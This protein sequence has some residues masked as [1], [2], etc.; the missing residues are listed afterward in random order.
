MSQSIMPCPVCDASSPS[1][2][3]E[4]RPGDIPLLARATH[5]GW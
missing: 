5:A 3:A 2:V 4:V 1:F